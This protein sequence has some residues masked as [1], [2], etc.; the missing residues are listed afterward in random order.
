MFL[1][2]GFKTAKERFLGKNPRKVAVLILLILICAGATFY[3]HF[4]LH[5]EVV[6]THFF[7]V[8]IV[9]AGLWWGRRGAW[10]AVL[11]GALPIVL[12]FLSSLA[13]PPQDDLLRAVMFMAVGLTVGFLKEQAVRSEK[14][15]R[16]TR[17]YLDNL[18][19]YANAPIIV[20]DPEFRITRFNHAFENLVGY[21][22]DEVIGQKLRMLFPKASRDESLNEI[23][24]TLSGEY[25]ESVEIPILRKDGDIRLALWNSANIYAEEGKTLLATIAQGTDITAR[26]QAEE[27]LRVRASEEKYR[28]IF[29]NAKEGISIYEELP[30]GSR[31]L[32]EC[33]PQY[34][35]MSGYSREEL[36][37]IS[38]TRKVQVTLNTPQQEVVNVEKAL[39]G[40]PYSGIFSWIRPDGIGNYIEYTA[41]RL[42]IEGNTFSERSGEAKRLFTVGID[43]DI[44][45]RK[46]AEEQI[47]ASLKEKEVLLREIHHRVKNN[48]QVISSLLDLQA[49]YVEDKRALEIFNESQNRIRTMALVHEY[50]YQSKDLA[51]IDFAEYIQDL[52]NSLFQPY[53]NSNAIRLR[54]NVEDDI[55]LDIDK[56]IPCGL[57]LNELVSNSLKHAFPAGE[58]DEIRIDFRSEKDK[59]M[60]IVSNNGVD[61]PKDLDFRN[62]E[63]LGL[64]I[65]VDLTEQLD[66]TVELDGSGG[67]TFKIAF[68]RLKEGG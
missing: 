18:I 68:P 57:I 42:N 40:Q 59:C 3:F 64:Q 29:E 65:V 62:T 20:W 16:E 49:D 15:L 34:A 22:A 5:I 9:L 58:E 2:N 4:T 56:A 52:A 28:M 32:V 27:V 50:L 8:P 39:A 67:T 25:W 41:A 7:Y 55:S 30:D 6:F 17:D 46:R 54:I 66:G 51:R 33:N 36:M 21:T 61:F 11:L 47:K 53:E 38:D 35:E 24:R 13:A 60:L 45:E 14:N 1:I 12:H 10:V 48:L 31:K 23:E 26:K 43:H 44:T 37:Q 19:H 63:S